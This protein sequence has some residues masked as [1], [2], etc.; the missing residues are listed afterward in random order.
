MLYLFYET[1]VLNEP[2]TS[3]KYAHPIFTRLA[4][5][6]TLAFATVY[7]VNYVNFVIINHK[8]YLFYKYTV[9]LDNEYI[10]FTC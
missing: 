8:K 4:Y 5:H 2:F 7:I 6:I 3:D 9:K 10:D 1:L